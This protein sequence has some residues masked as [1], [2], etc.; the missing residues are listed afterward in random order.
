MA[1]PKLR[2]GEFTEEWEK[3][4][5]SKYIK[6][7]RGSSP[8][9]IQLFISE[10]NDITDVNWI[11]IGDTKNIENSIIDKVNEKITYEGSLKSRQVKKGEL[12]L[13]NSMSFGKTYLLDLDGCI[14]DGWF[15]LREY[16]SF[17]DKQFLQYEL[18]SDFLQKQYKVLSTGGVVQNISS[19]IVYN[20]Y[21]LR[22]Q[23]EEQQKIASFLSTFDEKIE[24]QKAIIDSLELQ[25]KG[26]MQKIFSRELR[27]K[28]DNGE[29][30]EEWEESVIKNV[31]DVLSGKRVPKGMQF[32][33]II[34]E[35]AYI[36]VSDMGSKY[37][38][39]KNIK[40]ISSDV[41]SKIKKYK[42]NEN[43][44][45]I[46]VAGTLGK[47]NLVQK[48]MNNMNLT[49]NCDRFTNF[50]GINNLFLYFVLK[51]EKIQLNIIQLK[52]IGSQ[53]KLALDRIRG[54]E[55]P[56]PTLPEQEK[57]ASFLSAFD[58][59]INVEKELLEKLLNVKKGLL[60]EMFC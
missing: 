11:K 1:V 26:F 13:A 19:D 8:R 48:S 37:I 31:C 9:P 49:E 55:I 32:S 41:E 23:L 21:L 60:Q 25:K 34:T 12:I 50:Y 4:K 40:Y 51:S 52:T 18:N 7:Y 44:I 30:F 16:E 29:E 54:M 46:S 5:F 39:E 14:Y 15:V 42:V 10:K 27:F 57:I 2:F 56:L 3:N 45:I 59:K 58:D 6:L 35:I 47:I 38:N 24:N 36:T 43:D 53:P 20:T 33:D 17:F 28:N 22:P